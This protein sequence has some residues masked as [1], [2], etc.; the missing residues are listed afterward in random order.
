MISVSKMDFK[1][2]SNYMSKFAFLIWKI[3]NL[4][5]Y[6]FIRFKDISKITRISERTWS[7]SLYPAI[8][9]NKTLP[10]EKK[11]THSQKEVLI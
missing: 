6:T 9:V 4:D 3:L 5:I 7:R 2:F 1:L 10:A 11:H 8:G